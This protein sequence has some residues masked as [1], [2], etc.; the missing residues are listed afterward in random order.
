M[1]S[2]SQPSAAVEDWRESQSAFDRPL[3]ERLLKLI[4]KSAPHLEECIRWNMP[5]WK[6]RGLVCQVGGFKKHVSLMFSRGAE[7]DSPPGLSYEGEGC[8][9][10]R[11]AKFTALEQINDKVVSALIVAATALDEDESS[12]KPRP[13]KRPEAP[14]PPALAAA[15]AKSATARRAFD[16]LPPSHRR[17]YS[18]WIAGAK[19]E[20]TVQ[21]RV[22]KAVAKL[23]AGE[24]LN[25]KFQ[26]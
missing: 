19:Q 25:D 4:R 7:L 22:E 15:L 6:G 10:L 24:G 23:C 1:P 2:H 9:S 20:A 18:Q 13:Q 3:V 5:A 21:R 26:R 17:E 16:T 8:G 12:P 14:V 11:V